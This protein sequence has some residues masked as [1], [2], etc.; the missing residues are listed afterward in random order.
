MSGFRQMSAAGVVI[1][2]AVDQI[3][4]VLGEFAV[5]SGAGSITD[6]RLLAGKGF[7]FPKV[8]FQFGATRTFTFSG[9]TLSWSDELVAGP[10]SYVYGVGRATNPSY[11]SSHVPGTPG[12]VVRDDAGNFIIDETFFA[13]HFTAKVT[14][15]VAAGTVPVQVPFDYSNLPP[16]AIRSDVYVTPMGSSAGAGGTNLILLR[17]SG[18]GTVTI[19]FFGKANPALSGGAG[20]RW[21]SNTGELMGDTSIPLMNVVDTLPFSGSM[22]G[23]PDR[24]LSGARVG[25]SYAIMVHSPGRH[26]QVF[27]GSGGQSGG[28]TTRIS[29]AA[30]RVT[31]SGSQDYPSM[32]EV[33][34]QEVTSG[35]SAANTYV[36]GLFSLI[37]VTGL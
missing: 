23:G 24:Y 1:D 10:T 35:G 28:G 12:F 19:Y 37:D 2:S 17:T 14:A 13:Y 20:L 15:S 5:G 16:F 9:S 22:W 6:T 36:D 27:Q 31:T 8:P 21:Y 4:K 11:V 33:T 32:A 25:R 26:Y 18:A 30:A 29:A 34:L 3:G 7:V